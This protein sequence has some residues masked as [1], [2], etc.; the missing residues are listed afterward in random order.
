[1]SGKTQNLADR[2][3]E[4]APFWEAAAEGRLVLPYCGECGTFHWLPRGQCP[5]CGSLQ[6]KWRAASG[7]GTVHSL[8]TMHRESPPVTHAIV[9]LEEGVA[10][11]THLL[12]DDA[13]S[14]RIG[15]E[16]ACVFQPLNGIEHAVLFEPAP[17]TEG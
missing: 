6:W 11:M 7:R 16:V 15:M 14:L 3:P 10:M 2:T 5:H 9:L 4:N 12:A 17:G 8:S 1:M 13:G